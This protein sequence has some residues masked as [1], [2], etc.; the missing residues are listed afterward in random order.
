MQNQKLDG[1]NVSIVIKSADGGTF[2]NDWTADKKRKEEPTEALLAVIDYLG[3]IA[4]RSG[5]ADKAKEILE[6]AINGAVK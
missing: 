5:V 6:E 2:K 3:F 1:I 4:Q